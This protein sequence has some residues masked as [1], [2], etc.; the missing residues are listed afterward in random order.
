VNGKTHVVIGAVS[1]L[2]LVTA[3]ADLGQLLLL[4]GIAAGAAL[5]PDIDHP[6]ATATKALGTVVHKFVHTLSRTVRWATSTKADRAAMAQWEDLGRDADHRALTHTAVSSVAVGA[7]GFLLSLIPFGSVGVAA[8]MGWMAGH[9]VKRAT[10]PIVA[11]AFA[12]LA[13]ISGTPPWMTATA[14]AFGWMSHVLADACTMGGVPLMWPLKRRG[15]RWG[16]TRLMGRML[17]SGAV[18]EWA[19]AVA[20]V[21]VLSFPLVAT[22]VRNPN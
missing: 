21:A 11:I 18:S 1:P 19:V 13:V 8:L 10:A 16:H 5:G 14:L 15:R 6:N 17:R 7:A 20:F 4:S 9:V 3:G 12:G 22:L 2:V